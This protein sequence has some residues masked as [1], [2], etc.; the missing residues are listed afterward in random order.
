MGDISHSKHHTM[1]VD[2]ETVWSVIHEAGSHAEGERQCQGRETV[3]KVRGRVENK[4]KALAEQLR[5]DAKSLEQALGRGIALAGLRELY[6]F[7]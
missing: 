7:K 6:S 1:F 3:W 5:K 4:F 2:R